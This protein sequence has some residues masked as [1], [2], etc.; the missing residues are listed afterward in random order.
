MFKKCIVYRGSALDLYSLF[1]N[2]K[3]YFNKES[4]YNTE[5]SVFRLP[6]RERAAITIWS[7]QQSCKAVS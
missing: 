3:T 1:T 2:K 6:T 4:V 7:F 5:D